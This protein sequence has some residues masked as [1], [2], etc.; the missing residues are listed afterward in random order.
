M[1][2]V[3]VSPEVLEA[4]LAAGRMCCPGCDGPL[5]PWG[6]GRVRELRTLEGVRS[7]RPRRACC[8][9]CETT[10]VIVPAWSVPR[11]RD[12]AEVIGAALLAKAQG[13]GHR[14]IAA[15]LGRPP[16]TVRGWLRAFARRAEAVQS[17]ALRW[18]RTIDAQLEPAG[19]W[20]VV[21]RRRGRA[22]D[23]RQ[24]LPAVP[25]NTGRAVGACG[26]AHRRPAARPATRP[27]LALAVPAGRAGPPARPR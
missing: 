5:S 15:R 12:C 2:A 17:S 19:G 21:R 13:D 23:R 3:T 20:V 4:D 26:R 22:R 6:F 11:R 8:H 7:V 27:A 18:A 9:A 25:A 14:K 24:S 10:H 16:A 1:F